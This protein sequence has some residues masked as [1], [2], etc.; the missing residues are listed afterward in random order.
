MNDEE[1]WDFSSFPPNSFSSTSRGEFE[2]DDD[3]LK[4]TS[5]QRKLI[6][7]RAWFRTRYWDPANDTPYNSKEGGYLY[8]EGGPYSPR[9]D[10]GARFDGLVPEHLIN[11]VIDE[12]ES[13][14]GD[15]W[16]P[17][18]S[19]YD[20]D[21]DVD[22]SAPDE[23]LD[24]LIQRCTQNLDI[25]NL[26]GNDQAKKLS[27]KLVY[28]AMISALESFL[29]ETMVFYVENDPFASTNIIE[30]TEVFRNREIKLGNIFNQL[31]RIKED[32]RVHLQ[33]I[34]WHNWRQ[35]EPLFSQGLGIQMPSF[36]V[37]NEALLKR[38]DISHRSGFSKEGDEVVIEEKDVRELA[39]TV[40]SFAR[41]IQLRINGRVIRLDEAG[42]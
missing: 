24:K 4:K 1:T 9:E 18:H 34:V 13:E 30:K 26:Q 35:V 36:K 31:R 12:L 37:F 17:I 41:D 21:Y 6:A 8:V 16:A 22:V 39:D 14:V 2:P 27:L 7:M 33:N 19:Q 15:E 28:V 32:I 25:L 42:F 11:Q 40:M 29:W 3:W 5:S 20:E 38:H 10:L 23:P